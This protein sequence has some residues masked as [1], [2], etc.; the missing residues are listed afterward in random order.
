MNAIY[1]YDGSFPGL[2]CVLDEALRR[3]E[4]PFAIV[5]D[6]DPQSPL[7]AETLTIE[8]NDERAELF[9]HRLR[10]VF[11][12]RTPRLITRAFL[13]DHPRRDLSILEYLFFLHDTGQRGA[14]RLSHP[15]VRLLYD[16][17]RSVTCEAHRLTGLVRFIRTSSG[18]LVAP[19][20]PDHHV[21]PLIAPHF[22]KR[23]PNERWLIAD[24]RHDLAYYWDT[25]SLHEARPEAETFSLRNRPPDGTADDPYE[26]LWRGYFHAIAVAERRNPRC[27]R[28]FMPERYWRH[29]TEKR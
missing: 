1:R 4:R 27:Q 29:L 13:A 23:L 25:V 6:E 28:R 24:L 17:V 7:F 9:W 16:L 10:D 26:R 11:G 5:A 14:A 8:S 20:E 3:A 2:L 22:V 19:L 21:L 12:D 18:L 15:S